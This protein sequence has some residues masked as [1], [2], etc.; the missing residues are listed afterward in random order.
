MADLNDLF[1]VLSEG[2]KAAIESN[3]GKKRLQ[4]LSKTLKSELVPP[5]PTA[6]S[7]VPILEESVQ[8]Q[9]AKIPKVQQ[10]HKQAE[11]EK[12]LKVNATFQQPNPDPVA[13]D[14]KAIQSKLKFLE[15]AIGKIAATGPG[16]GE[17]NF[18]YLDDV[19]RSTMTPSNDNWLLEYDATTKKTQ[20]TNNIGPI[21]SIKLD[22]AGPDIAPVT[23]MLN[24]NA[25]NDC[26][27]VVQSGG[28][29]CQVG[30]ENYSQVYNDT[31]QMM[32]A[33]T[34]VVYKGVYENHITRMAVEPYIADGTKRVL[35]TVGVITEDIPPMNLGRA[36]KLGR[37]HNIDTT[38]AAVGENWQVGEE[39]WA[40]PTIPGALTDV[41]PTAP[42]SV[43]FV[44]IALHVHP[45]E[46]VIT[47]RYNPYS[48]M[49]YAS[50]Y[51][52]LVQTTIPNTPTEVCFSQ[53]LVSDG[54][55]LDGDNPLGYNEVVALRRGLYIFNYSIQFTSTNSSTS[56]LW[57]WLR[58][59]GVDVPFSTSS[60]TISANGGRLVASRSFYFTLLEEDY[61]SVMWTSNSSNVRIDN[62]ADVAFAPETPA[63]I[64]DI[65]Q[66]NL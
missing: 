15:Q 20:F 13:L 29:T 65:H 54:F 48:R 61:V 39:L 7:N 46:G 19:N 66:I 3:P 33:G 12:A 22:T 6:P 38:G 59:N 10:I 64:I 47:V 21:S 41:R 8:I 60:W 16:S 26:L 63:V 28:T 52:K 1:K 62:P 57:V 11:I 43:V 27:D 4:E 42:N 34:F 44:G 58:K 55:I 56:T 30:L 37:V 24:W 9:E 17:V 2:K 5:T 25:G 40:H 49:R 23:G 51:C 14:P 31:N 50:F 36:T 18:R 45:T 32:P 53:T 35:L